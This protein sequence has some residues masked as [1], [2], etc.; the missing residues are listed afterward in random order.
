VP[1][2]NLVVVVVDASNLEGIYTTPRKVIELGYRCVVALNMM[3]VA[4]ENGRRVD[5]EKLSRELGVPVV[6]ASGQPGTGS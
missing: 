2:L 1:P 6:P 4:E 3:D 5:T